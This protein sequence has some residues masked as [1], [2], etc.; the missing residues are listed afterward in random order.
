[1]SDLDVKDD[2]LDLAPTTDPNTHNNHPTILARVLSDKHI[3][4][5]IVKVTFQVAWNY[6]DIS[7]I[8]QLDSHTFA[9]SRSN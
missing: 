3:S 5:R 6:M 9:R 8:H 1:M 2:N 4:L 7:D